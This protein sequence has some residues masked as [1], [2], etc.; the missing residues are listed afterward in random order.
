MIAFAS[1]CTSQDISGVTTWI[2]RHIL[3]LR[4]NGEDV[5]VLLHGIGE[6]AEVSPF[7][8]TLKRNGVPVDFEYA[9]Y[10][11]IDS[12]K[13]TIKFLKKVS[14]R[15]FIPNCL[16]PF[17]YAASLMAK[18]G[19]P[20][21]YTLHSDDPVYWAMTEQINLKHPLASVVG[22]SEQICRKLRARGINSDC[23]PCG[24][25]IPSELAHFRNRPFKVAYCGRIVEEQKRIS[26][27]L[28]A[29]M[30]ACQ[31]NDS[32]ECIILGEDSAGY[33]IETLTS[34]R[35]LGERIKFLG[36]QSSD[37][38]HKQ[39][40]D[41]QAVLLMSDYEG[42]PLALL[43]AMAT[44]VVPVVKSIESGIPEL[45]FHRET[46][47]LVGDSP[48]EAAEAI[49]M[50]FA[51]FRLWETCSVNSRKLVQE[52]FCQDHALRKWDR[53]KTIRQLRT[54]FRIL[55]PKSHPA[56]SHVDRRRPSISQKIIKLS[57][58]LAGRLRR[59]ANR[60]PFR[61]YH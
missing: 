30:I 6:N 61:I 52:R 5:H 33:A 48:R 60:F 31:M 13:S 32:I 11:A 41:C 47:L 49:M 1:Y 36:R 15:V 27:V 17:T 57:R 21:V 39:L 3:Y 55:L 40:R 53:C 43:E 28:E 46:G 56:L 59:I 12:V 2:E 51:D 29:M 50:L 58:K 44:G 35:G 7:L 22:V 54:P 19:L 8:S 16:E 9:P 20:F 45:V 4:K 26:Q 23:I 38:V 18:Q 25:P 34:S 37:G 10:Y 42:L 14:P 24:T